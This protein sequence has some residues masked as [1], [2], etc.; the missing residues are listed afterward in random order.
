MALSWDDL[1]PHYAYIVEWWHNKGK[2]ADRAIL[3]A[4]SAFTKDAVAFQ[5]RHPY[6]IT[7]QAYSDLL[8][9]MRAYG[10]LPKKA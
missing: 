6:Q 3:V 7:L 10:R 4:T 1:K 5:R 9:L 8:K 2:A